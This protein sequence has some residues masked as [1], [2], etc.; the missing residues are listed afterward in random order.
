MKICTARITS[1]PLAAAIRDSYGISF[2]LPKVGPTAVAFLAAVGG[3][4]K[5]NVWKV[6]FSKSKCFGCV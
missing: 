2:R 6:F 4:Y 3:I 1:D 5:R